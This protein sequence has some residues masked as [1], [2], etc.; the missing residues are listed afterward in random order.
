MSNIRPIILPRR[1][2]KNRVI[3][4]MRAVYWNSSLWAIF[5]TQEEI[6]KAHPDRLHITASGR[7]IDFSDYGGTIL[8]AA[9]VKDLRLGW[10]PDGGELIEW[11]LPPHFKEDTVSGKTIDASEWMPQSYRSPQ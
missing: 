3:D 7:R 6:H 1:W 2:G 10:H 4:V 9:L 5:E 11:T 8:I